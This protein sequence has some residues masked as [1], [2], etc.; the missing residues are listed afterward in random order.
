MGDESIKNIEND[1]FFLEW[2]CRIGPL[3][4]LYAL[5]TN[6]FVNFRWF[7]LNSSVGENEDRKSVV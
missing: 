1:Q 4:K 3:G 6:S 7:F 5:E 2:I